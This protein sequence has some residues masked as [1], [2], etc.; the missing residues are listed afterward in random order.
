MPVSLGFIGA[1]N[2]NRTHMASARDL[3]LR[4]LGVADANLPAAQDAAKQFGIGKAYG[5]VN[6]MLADKQIT[7]VVVG[8]PNKFHAEHAIAALQA[9]KHV[10]LEK[11]MAMN[12]AEADRII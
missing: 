1:G 2:I 12:V 5:D 9:G 8:T 10:L 11:P 7:A 4:L 6:E 3:G